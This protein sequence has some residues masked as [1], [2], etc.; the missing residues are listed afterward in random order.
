MFISFEP[1]SLLLEIYPEGEFFFWLKNVHYMVIENSGKIGNNPKVQQWEIEQI[2]Y[3]AHV[4]ETV[5]LL[6]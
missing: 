2:K 5:Q 4:M 1:V 3:S 6:H